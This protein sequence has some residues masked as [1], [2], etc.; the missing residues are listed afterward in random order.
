MKTVRAI[1][2]CAAP[3]YSLHIG[4]VAALEDHI[5]DELIRIGYAVAVEEDELDNSTTRTDSKAAKRRTATNKK[6]NKQS[7]R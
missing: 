4:E 7:K 2:S 6:R 5:A 3:N 1:V